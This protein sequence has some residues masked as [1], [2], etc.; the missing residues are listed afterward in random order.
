MRGK[1]NPM[2]LLRTPACC[3]LLGVP[4]AQAQEIAAAKG[5][6]QA[7]EAVLVCHFDGIGLDNDPQALQQDWTMIAG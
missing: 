3:V 1:M 7:A 2:F 4:A 6:F 5:G